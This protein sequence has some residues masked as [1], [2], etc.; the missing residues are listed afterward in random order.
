VKL[1]SPPQKGRNRAHELQEAMGLVFIVAETLGT[2]DCLIDICDDPIVPAP[3]FIPK[4]AESVEV[5][6]THRTLNGHPS[7]AD[8]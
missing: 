7:S 6:T 4:S 3:D 1:I 2:I 8:A 5:A